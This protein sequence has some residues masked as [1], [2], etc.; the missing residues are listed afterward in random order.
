MGALT[1]PVELMLLATILESVLLRWLVYVTS[2]VPMLEVEND[3]IDG[4]SVSAP[5]PSTIMKFSRR[6]RFELNL[7]T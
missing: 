3:V 5:E 4:S 2:K 1:T 6:A 7:S